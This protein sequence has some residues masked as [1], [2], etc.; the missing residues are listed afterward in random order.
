MNPASLIV[1]QEYE[2]VGWDD[3]GQPTVFIGTH[4]GKNRCDAYNYMYLFQFDVQ[5]VSFTYRQV[6][7]EIEEIPNTTMNRLINQELSK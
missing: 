6:E 3:T 7:K 1:G 5:I 4:I 2:Y